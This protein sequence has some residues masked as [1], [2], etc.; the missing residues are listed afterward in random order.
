VSNRVLFVDDEPNVLQA[1]VRQHGRRFEIQTAL[2]CE[3]GVQ[4][5]IKDGPFA[6]VVSDLRMP[7]MDGINFL[8]MVRRFAPD[9]IRVML[10]GQSDPRLPM[11]AVD[12]A[13]I[14]RFLAKP[15]RPEVLAQTLESALEQHRLIT[16]KREPSK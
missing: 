12:E 6:V 4:A 15:C 2:G 11:E 7:G 3:E 14:F 10:T 8:S 5:I 13:N 9:T 1:L 16:T